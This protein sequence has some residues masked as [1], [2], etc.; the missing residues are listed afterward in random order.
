MKKFPLQEEKF[1]D[2]PWEIAE[3][4][5]KEYSAK[6]GKDQSLERIAERL[7]FGK[8]EII[9]LLFDRIKRIEKTL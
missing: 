6:Y 2:I 3:E 8:L 1:T 4:A 7:G 5:Y 9:L